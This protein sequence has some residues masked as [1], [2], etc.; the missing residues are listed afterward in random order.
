MAFLQRIV[1]GPSGALRDGDVVE[2]AAVA[3]ITLR[4]AD[5]GEARRYAA[6]L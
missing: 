1:N 5:L 4:A 6:G 2:P 3:W